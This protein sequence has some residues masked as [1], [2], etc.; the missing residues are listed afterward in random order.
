MERMSK[1]CKIISSLGVQLYTFAFLRE[2]MKCEG[3]ECGSG[4]VLVAD[5]RNMAKHFIQL[6]CRK[7]ESAEWIQ[8]RLH[9]ASLPNYFTGFTLLNLKNNQENLETFLDKNDFLPVV[10]T[11]G[12]LPDFLRENCFIMKIQQAD[13]E[14]L[15]VEDFSEK[16]KKLRHLLIEFIQ[17]N[18]KD[19]TLCLKKIKI[20]DKSSVLGAWNFVQKIILFGMY[21][22][23][24]YSE[25]QLCFLKEKLDTW[26]SNKTHMFEKLQ[27]QKSEVI[28]SINTTMENYIRANGEFEVIERYDTQ[29]LNNDTGKMMW[30]DEEFYYIS[31][32]TFKDMCEKLLDFVSWNEFKHILQ[33]QEILVCDKSGDYTSKVIIGDKKK[34]RVLKLN[35]V[36]LFQMSETGN[37]LEEIYEDRKMEGKKS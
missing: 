2:I 6:F 8:S 33:E 24:I 22:S 31:E 3:V 21:K 29:N 1:T 17:D 12:I 4:I 10:V 32:R 27:H 34:V 14:M 26:V 16:I 9:N 23:D 28:E 35:K 5:D 25:E 13:I 20:E 30:Y 36:L 18:Q 7:T 11:G 15:E 19:S 37:F